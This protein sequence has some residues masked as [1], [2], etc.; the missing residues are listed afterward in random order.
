MKRL[1]IS[2]NMWVR[3]YV[4]PKLPGGLGVRLPAGGF[5]GG[6]PKS[7]HAGV[8]P[9][10]KRVW[11]RIAPKDVKRRLK[12]G[13]AIIALRGHRTDRLWR[14][15]RLVDRG[16]DVG[17]QGFAIRSGLRDRLAARRAPRDRHLRVLDHLIQAL[18]VDRVPTMQDRDRRDGRE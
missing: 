10:A 17:P 12:L 18:A 16:F 11:T 6:T 8:V 4:L 13:P 14:H 3:A 7:H 2:D 5:G 9:E 15:G 1:E